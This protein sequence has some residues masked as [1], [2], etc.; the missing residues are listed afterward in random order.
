MGQQAFARGPWRRSWFLASWQ[1]PALDLSPPPWHETVPEC[2]LPS[3]GPLALRAHPLSAQSPQS[4]CRSRRRAWATSTILPGAPRCRIR[5]GTSTPG[6][7]IVLAAGRRRWCVAGLGGRSEGGGGVVHEVPHTCDAPRPWQLA[8][9]RGDA[10]A[11]KRGDAGI[12]TGPA[13]TCSATRRSAWRRTRR[14]TSW[15]TCRPCGSCSRT[16]WP[17]FAPAQASPRRDCPGRHGDGR[18]AARTRAARAWQTPDLQ[19]WEEGVP[20]RLQRAVESTCDGAGLLPSQRGKHLMAREGS[21]GVR[22][23]R[24]KRG[25]LHGP[26]CLSG[27][28]G[29]GHER[30]HWVQRL[31][32]RGL[33]VAGGP[34][35]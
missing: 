25:F 28:M 2:S 11:S 29:S 32:R 33:P 30:L 7:M 3:T 22:D 20:A 27:R 4:R 15:W 14:W 35:P 23:P 9:E 8:G 16:G 10:G 6:T 31:L 1:V 17:P 34:R 12:S 13:P 5:R 21:K 19:R 24:I 26:W 18:G